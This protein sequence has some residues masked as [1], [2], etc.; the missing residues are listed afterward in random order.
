M[1]PD[2]LFFLFL[3]R[4]FYLLCLGKKTRQSEDINYC[5]REVKKQGSAING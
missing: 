2:F 1:Y 4:R 5:K 3:W